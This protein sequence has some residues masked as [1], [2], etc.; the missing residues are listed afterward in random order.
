MEEGGWKREEGRERMRRREED[1]GKT[2]GWM[3]QDEGGK[4]ERM[5]ED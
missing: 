3:R 1:G 5:E 4:S 2:G